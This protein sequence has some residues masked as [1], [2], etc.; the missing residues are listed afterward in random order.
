[1]EW[2]NIGRMGMGTS[3]FWLSLAAHRCAKLLQA[4][5]K[6]PSTALPSSLL[7]AAYAYVRLVSSN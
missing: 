7:V 3:V 6:H 1:M 5:E 4:A 2:W